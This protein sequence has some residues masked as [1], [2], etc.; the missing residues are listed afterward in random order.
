[1]KQKLTMTN[2]KIKQY[3]SIAIVMLLFTACSVPNWLKKTESNATPNTYN[4]IN[5][6]DSTNSSA[7]KWK[8]FFKD[9]NLTALI[10]EALQKNQELNI[11]LQNI[12]IA[13]NNVRGRKG[14]YL[15][16]V[17]AGINAGTEKVGRYTSQGAND[18]NTEIMPGKEF[19]DPLS[20]FKLGVN[21][22]W[23]VD[24]WN[25]LRNAKKAAVHN[26]LATTE[27]KNFMVTTLIAEIANSY[28]ELLSLDNQLDILK[29]NIDIQLNALEI[30]KMEKNSARVTE[31][32]VKKF[33]AE[34]LKNQSHQY[35]IQQN[36]V[37][38]E[39]HINFLVGRFPTQIK[40]NSQ[41]F[42]TTIPDSLQTGIPSQLLQNRPDIRQAE[43]ELIASKLEVKSAK[44][45]F[46][47]SMLIRAGLGYQAF[48]PK[49]L[50]QT[51][52]SLIY[53][54]AGDLVAPL[55]NRNAI[56]ATFYNANA[57]QVQAAYHYERAILQGYIEVSNQLSNIDN[58]KKSFELKNN[59]VQT[60]NQSIDISTM[61]F[62]S[63]RADYMEVLMTQRDALEAKFELIE[64]KKAQYHAS[65]NLYQALGGGWR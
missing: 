53:S 41:D 47:P 36:I 49:Y 22:A 65:I 45:E 1:M 2:F 4:S 11:M 64:T 57:K 56:K 6:K 19:P 5:T 42:L 61:L 51:P 18:A 38:I 50:L 23:E 34:V 3:G 58:M 32:A 17:G 39:N 30:V 26:Y 52:T 54:L 46:Y 59:Q 20:D 27:G 44:A 33:E 28:Y 24:I 9:A 14:A 63:A 37:E 16:F 55:I 48:D 29:K 12:N 35:M 43:Q 10:D 13:K 25:K 15:P 62:K 60:L 8:D 40:R 31:L 7:I 21:L